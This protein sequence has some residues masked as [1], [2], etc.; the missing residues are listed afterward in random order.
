ML[1]NILIF[2]LLAGFGV[3]FSVG[4]RCKEYDSCSVNDMKIESGR[5]SIEYPFLG[6]KWQP[7]YTPE[8]EHNIPMTQIGNCILKDRNA[9]VCDYNL[10]PYKPKG[11]IM[12]HKVKIKI[13]NDDKYKLTPALALY[14]NGELFLDGNYEYIKI[15]NVF[16]NK[17]YKNPRYRVYFR[18]NYITIRTKAYKYFSIEECN[19]RTSQCK[20]KS[21]TGAC[22][23]SCSISD[24]VL[25]MIAYPIGLMYMFI[26]FSIT[27]FQYHN[28]VFGYAGL[29][30]NIL[31]F[32]LPLTSYAYLINPIF[33]IF[34]LAK[35]FFISGY[36][37]KKYFAERPF[38]QIRNI[39][40][41]VPES[42]SNDP[43]CCICLKNSPNIVLKHKNSK[44]CKC[45]C[46]ECV[47]RFLKTSEK[48]PFC[49]NEIQ[50]I[51]VCIKN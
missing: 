14:V 32:I 13:L 48:C 33:M 35:I 4:E 22:D 40:P 5:Y 39:K 6:Y 27:I 20:K 43:I 31:Y 2:V 26:D 30:V 38:R 15:N 7:Y 42:D 19:L 36:H 25:F 1:Q 41:N 3:D 10:N 49:R 46:N 16:Y 37:I 12:I 8:Y 44:G 11:N 45:V 34:M 23:T 9:T 18:D 47:E 50:G 17:F 29:G 28:I 21:M 24:S 51:S